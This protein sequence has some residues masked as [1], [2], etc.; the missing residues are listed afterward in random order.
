MDILP[1]STQLWIILSPHLL[2]VGINPHAKWLVKKRD[3]EVR[4]NEYRVGVKFLPSLRGLTRAETAH[5]TRLTGKTIFC[6]KSSIF[7][8]YV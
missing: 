7:S 3:S 2:L 6:H 4:S 8:S 5:Q 1:Y